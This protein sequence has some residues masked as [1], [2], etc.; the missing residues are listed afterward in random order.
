MRIAPALGRVLIL[1]G[2]WSMPATGALEPFAAA[3]FLAS[4]LPEQPRTEGGRTSHVQGPLGTPTP[5]QKSQRVVALC[6]R[7]LPVVMSV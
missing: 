4:D 3:V 1:Q 2:N 5:V 7:Q 6:V